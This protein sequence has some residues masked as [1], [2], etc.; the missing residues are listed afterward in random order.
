MED[1][2]DQC[3]FHV[4]EIGN[5][6]AN[7]VPIRM[8]DN[9][10]LFVEDGYGAAGFGMDGVQESQKSCLGLLVGED[11]LGCQGSVFPAQSQNCSRQ[12]TQLGFP[13]LDRGNFVV[14]QSFILT[15]DRCMDE[16]Q[17]VRN[18][19]HLGLKHGIADVF[20][21]KKHNPGCSDNQDE[22]HQGN[23]FGTQ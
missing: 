17:G 20:L 18:G 6:F 16:S 10:I 21:G 3:A 22:K 9:V 4:P 14:Q 7:F 2:V 13:G 12:M 5:G 19:A 15:F 23:D 8:K 11:P 1:F